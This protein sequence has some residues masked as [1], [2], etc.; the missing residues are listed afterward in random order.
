MGEP[1]QHSVKYK[2]SVE[3]RTGPTGQLVA[4]WQLTDT[5]LLDAVQIAVP[6]QHAIPIVFVPGIMGSNLG[7]M[8]GNPVWLLNTIKGQPLGL[9]AKW[10]PKEAGVRQRLLHPART[11]VYGQGSVPE[12]SVSTGLRQDDFLKRG[13][14]EVSEASYHKFLLWL[15]QKMN[16]SRNPANWEDFTHPALATADTA[17]K[18]MFRQLPAGL[19]MSMSGLPETAESGRR[20]DPVTSDELLKR[21]KATYPIYACG[22]NWLDSNLLA[23][24]RLKSRIESIIAENDG[25]HIRCKQVIVVTHSMGGL[26]ARACAQLPGMSQRIVGVVHGVM[27][28]TGAAVAYRR[29]KVGMRDE[30]YVAGLVIGSNGQEVTA[31]FAQSP[32]ALQ[33][34]PSE[35][36]GKGWL[37]VCDVAGNPMIALPKS[38][39]YEE[40][41]LEKKKWWGLIREE[42]LRP[43]DGAALDWEDFVTNIESARAFHRQ[44]TKSY[45]HN[46]FVFYVGG[47][48]KQ[49]FQNVRWELKRGNLHEHGPAQADVPTLSHN[50]LRTDGFTKLFVGGENRS[51]ITQHG[52]VGIETNFWEIRC[53]TCDSEGDGTVP[54]S[55]GRDPLLSGGKNVLQQFE[56]ADIEHEPAYKKYPL[57]QQVAYY[58]ITK[59]CALADFK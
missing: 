10:S 23:A 47:K 55:S 50:E 17:E 48:K 42:W 30:D 57:A 31:V 49:S 16:G 27:P 53:A 3:L 12:S 32:G 24:R 15:D 22:Y 19:V 6:P 45:H 34:L 43:P 52:A 20:V 40:I 7:D 1:V 5:K 33:L 11:Q 51:I 13:W 9:A 41:Y 25:P 26:V 8:R 38:D 4:D 29:C 56:L 35:S 21:A 37:S 59:L 36:Y 58:A 44:I 14:G 18:K 28:A 54:A 39:P 46:S 2:R